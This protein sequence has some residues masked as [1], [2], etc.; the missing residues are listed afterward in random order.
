T[1][2]ITDI[3]AGSL[4]SNLTEISF[5]KNPI[6]TIDP[7]AFD[8]S[9]KTLESLSFSEA[10][11][12][13][14]PDAI[15]HLRALNS[16]SIYNTAIRD[17]NAATLMNIGPTLETLQFINVSLTAWPSWMQYFT[18][19]T[20]L[21]FQSNA[22]TDVPNG[23]FDAVANILQILDISKNG[24]TDT[25]K[26]VSNLNVL[27]SLDLSF[28]HIKD[29]TFL[30][31]STSLAQ[32]TLM[33]NLISD[34]NQLSKAVRPMGNTLAGVYIYANKLTQ[35]PD[36]SF[37]SN[38]GDIDLSGNQISDP[39]SGSLPRILTYLELDNNSLP[40]I[41]QILMT[42]PAV[43]SVVMSFNRVT[44]I[45]ATEYPVWIEELQL[46]YNLITELTEE[47]FHVNSSINTIDLMYNPIKKIS[48]HA[49]DNLLQ[50]KI[51]NLQG[52]K[53]AR[54]PLALG[55]L[56]LL[57]WLDITDDNDL[58]CTCMEK[59]LAPWI[60]SRQTTILASCGETD[61]YDFFEILSQSCPA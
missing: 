3:P 37:M 49:F 12:T 47:S 32:L 43:D 16:F 1:N 55:S 7:T 34:A 21:S 9:A 23:S 54:L 25:P 2:N 17:W 27:E 59:S 30:P 19:L 29:I 58:V 45:I 44:N 8:D 56:S 24:L 60:L 15:L 4:P 39:T 38:L 22:I 61:I 14:I 33:H 48:D 36:L 11:F 18:H 53:L 41:P 35:I 51:L 5:L 52:T 28:N 57:N 31:N 10:L 13:T 26:A 40:S 46:G 20:E 50:L 6:T 42:L